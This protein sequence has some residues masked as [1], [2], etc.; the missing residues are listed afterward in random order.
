MI[1]HPEIRKRGV[2]RLAISDHQPIR[3]APCDELAETTAAEDLEI[4][5]DAGRAWLFMSVFNE[6]PGNI[7]CFAPLPEGS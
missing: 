4:R 2:D 7:L 6:Q 5:M 3:L 1:E